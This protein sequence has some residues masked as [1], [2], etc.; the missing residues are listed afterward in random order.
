MLVQLAETH[1][2][3]DNTASVEDT[4]FAGVRERKQIGYLNKL[5]YTAPLGFSMLFVALEAVQD[6]RAMVEMVCKCSEQS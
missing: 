1:E 3:K 5:T 4:M 6:C 2:A